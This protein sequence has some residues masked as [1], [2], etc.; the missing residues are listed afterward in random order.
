MVGEKG[1][2]LSGGQRQRVCIARAAY[3]DSDIILLDDPLSAVDAHVADHL[4]QACILSGPPAHRTRILVTHNL[5]VLPH[6]DLVVMMQSD[7]SVGRIIQQ[8]TYKVWECQ[9]DG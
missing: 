5:N 6:A 1:I 7:G 9:I 3:A 2:T 4:L 8:G